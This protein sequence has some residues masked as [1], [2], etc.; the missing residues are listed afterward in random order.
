MYHAQG[1]KEMLTK[2]LFEIF[3]QGVHLGNKDKE[4]SII[5]N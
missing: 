1:E 4:G 3:R 2:F 5:L